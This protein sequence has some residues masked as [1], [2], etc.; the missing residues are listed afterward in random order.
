MS[1]RDIVTGDSRLMIL[2]VAAVFAVTLCLVDGNSVSQ[3]LNGVDRM[4]YGL[5]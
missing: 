3:L 1:S 4:L 2:A 5:F